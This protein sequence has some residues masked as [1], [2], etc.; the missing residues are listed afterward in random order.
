MNDAVLENIETFA[1]TL[2][3]TSGL[4]SRIVLSPVNGVVE[5]IDNDGECYI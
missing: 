5:I 4:D 1:V 3:R 2:A